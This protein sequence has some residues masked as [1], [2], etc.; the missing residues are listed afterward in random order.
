MNIEIQLIYCQI[1]VYKDDTKNIRQYLKLSAQIKSPDQNLNKNSFLAIIKCR[2]SVRDLITKDNFTK[3]SQLQSLIPSKFRKEDK[4]LFILTWKIPI[5]QYLTQIHY[6]D[7]NLW[8]NSQQE[9]ELLYQKNNQILRKQYTIQFNALYDFESLQ[10]IMN[11]KDLFFDDE[12]KNLSQEIQHQLFLKRSNN[13]NIPI[14]LTLNQT[15][16][17]QIDAKKIEIKLQSQILEH[18]FPKVQYTL[19][20]KIVYPQ[21][22]KQY[23]QKL[24]ETQEDQQFTQQNQIGLDNHCEVNLKIDLNILENIKPLYLGQNVESH[25]LVLIKII[26]DKKYCLD[27]SQRIFDIFVPIQIISRVSNVAQNVCQNP[28][29]IQ[30]NKIKIQDNTIQV[31]FWPQFCKQCENY[32]KVEIL[33]EQKLIIKSLA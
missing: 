33:N 5:S 7:Q 27:L 14:T 30:N 1:F 11:E 9:L 26:F 6:K 13:Y 18:P 10:K 22:Q 28:S 21:I 16:F 19:Y 23:Y 29:K 3:Y 2:E 8:F 4:N 24:T 32:L 17:K 15:V 20:Q 25:H 12:K 31:D